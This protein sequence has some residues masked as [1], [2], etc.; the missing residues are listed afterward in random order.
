MCRYGEDAISI[1]S[2]R[3][4]R[5]PLV[6][7]IWAHIVQYSGAWRMKG[8]LGRCDARD[9]VTSGIPRVL[10]G[11]PVADGYRAAGRIVGRRFV[12]G[13]ADGRAACFRP[14]PM[15]NNRPRMREAGLDVSPPC[16]LRKSMDAMRPARIAAFLA[17]AWRGIPSWCV[18]MAHIYGIHVWGRG[19][20]RPASAE[21]RERSAASPVIARGDVASCGPPERFHRGNRTSGVCFWCGRCFICRHQVNRGIPAVLGDTPKRQSIAGN[22]LPCYSFLHQTG[23]ILTGREHHHPSSERYRGLTPFE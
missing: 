1:V 4:G 10:S 14:C 23:S 7:V 11:V 2:Y 20:M 9:C 22:R 13:A 6:V 17:R 19:V 5:K 15:R 16:P 12:R 8:A 3:C 18:Y 21:L